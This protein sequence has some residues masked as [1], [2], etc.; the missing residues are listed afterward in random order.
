MEDEEGAA[1]APPS[2]CCLRR[3]LLAFDIKSV[4]ASSPRQLKMESA[5]SM[6]AWP[7]ENLGLPNL[8]SSSNFVFTTRTLH[9][10]QGSFPRML[11]LAL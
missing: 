9:T 1:G 10:W 6:E 8:T 2:N 7:H 5:A 3:F 4:S 11:F